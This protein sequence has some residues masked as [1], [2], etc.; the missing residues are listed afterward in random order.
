MRH[1]IG[2]QDERR[3][4]RRRLPQLRRHAR[5]YPREEPIALPDAAITAARRR[6]VLGEPRQAAQLVVRGRTRLEM[7]ED[8]L[9]HAR[10]RRRIA[11]QSRCARLQRLLF[12]PPRLALGRGDD[13]PRT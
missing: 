6:M 12:E 5:I 9:E 8:R 13:G 7:G 3:I 2:Q 4:R 10:H 11:R 1:E